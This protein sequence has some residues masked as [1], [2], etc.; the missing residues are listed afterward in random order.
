MY[1]PETQP[2]GAPGTLAD[3]DGVREPE[4]LVTPRRC[5]QPASAGAAGKTL[6]L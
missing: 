4:N 1:P 6:L 5:S 3:R 2:R